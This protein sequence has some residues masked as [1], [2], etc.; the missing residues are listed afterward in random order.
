MSKY[1]SRAER[2]SEEAYSDPSAYLSHRADLVVSLG[3]ALEPGD[4]VLD[5]ACAD[6]GLGEALLARGIRYHGVD[7]S[8]AMVETA[9][10][11]LSGRA[12][13]EIGDLNDFR[14]DEPVACT[15]CF[16]AIYYARDRRRFFGAAAA[17]TEGKLVFDLNPR[18]YRVRD[19]VADLEASGLPRVALHPFFVPQR[20]GL[21]RPLAAALRGAERSKLLAD[22]LLRVRF[23]YLVAASRAV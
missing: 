3:P 7:L 13:V 18:Q 9:S 15:T 1:D 6:G 14:P 20:V 22:A 17:Y 21:P 10:R 12:P 2:W 19:V 11:R 16:R 4:T 8:P 5:L 23:S